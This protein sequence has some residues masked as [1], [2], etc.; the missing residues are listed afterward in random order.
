MAIPTRT[1]WPHAISLRCTR[2]ESQANVAPIGPPQ[3][4]ADSRQKLVPLLRKLST[5]FLFSWASQHGV[6]EKFGRF[7]K[8]FRRVATYLLLLFPGR[9]E[10][11][12]RGF[13]D[14]HMKRDL[15]VSTQPRKDRHVF[16]SVMQ[17]FWDRPA[18]RGPRRRR[19]SEICLSR[20]GLCLS[21][22]ML[23]WLRR[24]QLPLSVDAD[25]HGLLCSYRAS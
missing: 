13:P 7:L 19:D 9:N 2:K 25:P 16:S 10:S 5:H 8:A 22:R 15:K 11:P 4:D 24:K 6:K 17:S 1:S 14:C 12:R 23:L 3:K 18:L 21:L 20:R